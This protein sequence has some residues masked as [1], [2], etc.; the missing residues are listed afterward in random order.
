MK[1]TLQAVLTENVLTQAALKWTIGKKIGLVVI[2]ASAL[3]LILGAPIAYLKTLVFRIDAMKLLGHTFNE[4]LSTYF[5]LV[6]NLVILLIAL[7]L[8]LRWFVK[9]PMT[10]FIEGIE[11]I[12][13]NGKIDLSRRIVLQTRD[14]TK[15]LADYFNK[16]LDELSALTA[17]TTTIVNSINSSSSNLNVQARETGE[18]SQQVA[19]TMGV[20]SGGIVLQS[21]RTNRIVTMMQD[22]KRRADEA[23]RQIGDTA[24]YAEAATRS[25][26]HADT[27]MEH[28]VQQLQELNRSVRAS[29]EAIQ[30]LGQKSDEIGSI[31]GVIADIAGQTNL[32]ALN[33]AIEAA[34]AGEHGQ[35]FAVVASEVRKLSEQTQQASAQIGELITDIQQETHAT[36]NAMGDNLEL[37]SKQT[38]LIQ[39]GGQSVKTIVEGTA[40]TDQAVKE[41][42]AI[43]EAVEQN[44]NRVLESVEEISSVI[45]QSSA[46]FQQVSASSQEQSA[47]VTEMAAQLG[48]LAELSGSLRQ[49]VAKFQN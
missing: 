47:I 18:V 24:V 33:A 31:I 32:L 15:L 42:Q 17:S 28:A 10:R 37:V 5:T 35:G 25:A 1:K 46:S 38:E 43:I 26:I 9:R 29:T 2:A 19:V 40:K 8:S 39:A 21:E 49:E 16:F 48:Q 36:V 41:L 44:S 14:E 7:N 27:A 30:R 34:R 23:G 13:A 11:A 6:V 22:T 4:M 12:V 20:L 3:S 45:Q